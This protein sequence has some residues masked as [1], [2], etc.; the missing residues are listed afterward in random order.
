MTRPTPNRRTVIRTAAWSIPVVSVAAAAPAFATT[1]PTG[2][3]PDLS[4]S[5]RQAG[6]V[7]LG[8]TGGDTVVVVSAPQFVNTGGAAATG[9]IMTVTS[10]V[11]ITGYDLTLPFG[12]ISPQGTASNGIAVAGVGTTEVEISFDLPFFGTYDLQAPV[13]PATQTQ[14]TMFVSSLFYYEGAA[15]TSLVFSAVAKNG[16]APGA[17][18]VVVPV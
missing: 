7:R 15:P 4:L 11:P 10:D 6:N 1:P 12:P 5:N 9:V 2:P 17:W 13:A 3:A 18:T 14:M 16:G 8:T